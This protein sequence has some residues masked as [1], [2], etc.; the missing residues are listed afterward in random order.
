MTVGIL[1]HL[2]S[3]NVKFQEINVPAGME[4]DTSFGFERRATEPFDET[5]TKFWSSESTSHEEAG[6]VTQVGINRLIQKFLEEC[7]FDVMMTINRRRPHKIIDTKVVFSNVKAD[8]SHVITDILFFPS[9]M[10]NDYIHPIDAGTLTEFK[11]I[12]NIPRL[13]RIVDYHMKR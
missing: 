2:F 7:D 10:K 8:S 12:I 4:S 6:T 1:N 13:V 9:E 11:G 3:I 5:D